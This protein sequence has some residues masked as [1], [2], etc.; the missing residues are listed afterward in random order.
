VNIYVAVIKKL[1][2]ARKNPSEFIIRADYLSV[3]IIN[4]KHGRGEGLVKTE[5]SPND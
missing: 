2:N 5:V 3:G 1:G 4:T